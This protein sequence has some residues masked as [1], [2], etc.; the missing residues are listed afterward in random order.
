[1]VRE[2]TAQA[3]IASISTPV[4]PSQRTMAR[5]S[6]VPAA[7]SMSNVTSMVLRMMGC[8]SGMSDGVCFA[9]RTPAI[10]AVVRTS[11]FGSARPTSLPSVSGF[12]RTV[13]AATASREV[14]R[15]APTSTMEMPPVSSRC[16]KSLAMDPLRLLQL[17]GR[18]DVHQRL[19]REPR[20]QLR[21]RDH[22]RAGL[23][24]QAAPSGP[25]LF[26]APFDDGRQLR[27]VRGAEDLRLAPPHPNASVLH[28][29]QPL[30]RDERGVDGEDEAA[31]LRL[32]Q[33]GQHAE[34]GRG[35]FVRRIV[36]PAD[37]DHVVEHL[38]RCRLHAVQ[39]QVGLGEPHPP[40]PAAR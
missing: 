38:F 26:D 31:L 18:I 8:A 2:A 6:I 1:M 19:A 29:R 17:L 34:D 4:L 40:R 15:F 16:E 28:E 20:A 36:R 25:P 27:V 3:V 30:G 21:L 32:L 23:L 33:P 24:D 39:E 11:P 5:T 35:S 7:W 10:L 9:A 37:D 22:L 13:A 14:A 12:M